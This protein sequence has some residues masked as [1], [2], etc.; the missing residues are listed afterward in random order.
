VNELL[1]V[2]L[3]PEDEEVGLAVNKDLSC[4]VFECVASTE[5]LVNGCPWH[6]NLG[7]VVR[8]QVTGFTEEVETVG[9]QD[10]L[11]RKLLSG[12][13]TDSES[14]ELDFGLDHGVI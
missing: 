13:Y 1:P 10:D 6:G 4:P 8:G 11:T 7:T 5:D 9:T 2:P 14:D 3:R 12:Y